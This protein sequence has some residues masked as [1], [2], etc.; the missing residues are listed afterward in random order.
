MTTL[1]VPYWRSDCGRHTLYHGDCLAI[2]PHLSGVD[3]VVTDPP[4]GITNIHWDK[5][6][7]CTPDWWAFIR[8]LLVTPNSPVVMTAIGMATFSA[9]F[10]AGIPFRWKSVWCR[11]GKVTG[12]LD[13]SK[14][15]MRCH[16]DVLV[17]AEKEPA[18]YPYKWK[19]E[20]VKSSSRS[21]QASVLYGRIAIRQLYIAEERFPVDIFTFQR[22]DSRCGEHPTQK[23]VA[24]M[25]HL[26]RLHSTV[27][28]TVLDPFAGSGTTGV[29]CAMTGRRFIG[30]E[31][32]EGYC[33]IAKRRIEE[34]ANHLF[35]PTE[36]NPPDD[37]PP[38][39]DPA[40][41]AA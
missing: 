36:T 22:D 39:F 19:A 7:G 11:G 8:V 28:Q 9:V 26:V 17:F 25:D 37:D 2:L 6:H 15:P 24:L 35:V 16:E 14:R 27:D 18:Y 30:I 32:D 1:P 12:Y 34:A 20:K 33:A 13:A 21:P 5:S 23:P 10:G 41:E 4:Y 29:A 31:I 40:T 38:L 3:A